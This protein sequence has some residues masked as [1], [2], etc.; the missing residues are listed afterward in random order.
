MA[1]QAFSPKSSLLNPKFDGYKLKILEQDTCVRSYALPAPGATQSTVSTRRVVP[2]TE[3]SARIKHN[4]LRASPDGTG[5]VYVDQNGGVIQ[6]K[7]SVS[8]S[9][10]LFEPEYYFFAW[11]RSKRGT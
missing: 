5:A 4:H 10:L 2:F 3:V 1:P 6:I 11:L 8:L 7:L 9:T